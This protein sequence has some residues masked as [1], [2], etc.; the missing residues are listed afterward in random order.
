MLG[1]EIVPSLVAFGRANLDRV[2]RGWAHIEQ[3]DP[4]VLGWPTRAPYDRVLVSAEARSLPEELAAQLA[5][6]GVMVLPVDGRWWCSARAG[7]DPDRAARPLRIRA[8][9]RRLRGSGREVDDVVRVVVPRLDEVDEVGDR[10][11]DVGG[12]VGEA[13]H[14]VAPG[15]R[16][17]APGSS[18]ARPP[19]RRSRRC[20]SGRRPSR[21]SRSARRCGS[22]PSASSAGSA[23][24]RSTA[25]RRSPW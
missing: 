21:W 6:D 16:R 10:V 7:P 24:R 25:R 15:R 2:G 18:A 5:D 1:V 20:P 19:G 17:S 8:A 23:C 13:L 12:P 11:D 14:L 3:A 22:A 9:R 4:G